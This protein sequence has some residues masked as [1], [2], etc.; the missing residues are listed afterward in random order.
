LL[1]F[2]VP[3]AAMAVARYFF[4]T[5]RYEDTELVVRTGII[6]KN[7]RHIPFAR[8]QSVDAVQNVLHRM[9][10]VVDVKV[11]TGTGGDAEATLSV[12]PFSALAE[13]RRRAFE[14]RQAPATATAPDAAFEAGEPTDA[15]S[16]AVAPE[17]A[18]LL[19][20]STRDLA[21]AGFLDNRGWVVIGAAWGLLFESGVLDRFEDFDSSS[22]PF[23][24]SML[25]GLFVIAPVLSMLWATVRLHGF[26]LTRIGADLRIEYGALT[27][28]TATI[29]L[30]RVQAIK[31]I[32]GPGHLWT[33]R[34][35]VRV[36]T[37]GGSTTG[38]SSAEREWIAPIIHLDDL[39][40]F[41]RAVL[42]D[43][44]LNTLDWHPVDARGEQRRRRLVLI[45]ASIWGGA[46]APWLGGLWA[47]GVFA[48][49]ALWWVPAAR[50]Y[51]RS[52]GWARTE[53]VMAFKKGWLWRVTTVVPINKIQAADFEESPFDRRWQMACLRVDTAG[54]GAHRI[55]IPYLDRA[56]ADAARVA[57]ARDAA[58]T[59]FRW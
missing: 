19:Q 25:V 41:V 29:P 7:E 49:L 3:A 48:G 53:H 34:A 1:V 40:A 13:I 52:L 17:T 12:L 39:T 10:S 24:A 58:A 14:G 43:A 47:L 4:S 22:W 57:L 23:Y 6:F 56:T 20:L 36:E 51:V 9:C 31:I 54:A 26:R 55:D 50:L 2:L 45:W 27:R 11:R 18:A 5:Y 59:T 15:V 33:R 21:L 30:R 8:I 44:D 28:V 46:T 42:P 37:A 38:Q 16:E 32:R 35:S